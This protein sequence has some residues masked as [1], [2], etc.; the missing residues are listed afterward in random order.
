MANEHRTVKDILMITTG[1][2]LYGF[3]LVY[4]NIANDLAEG[5][6][7]GIALL[8]RFWLSIDPAISSLLL[9]IPM[10]LIG[11]KF[12]G[13]RALIYTLYGTVM[14]S[15]FLWIWQRVPLSIQLDNDLFI[16]GI[17]AGLGG[18]IGS[19]LIY[20]VGGTTGGSDI[21]A[22]ILEKKIG[23][24]MGKTLLIFDIFVLMLSLSYI[25][26]PHMMYTL[27][28]SYVFS[29]V[30]DFIQE[31]AYSARGM[32]VISNE[33]DAIAENLMLELER[34]VTFLKAEGAYSKTDKNVL[35]CVMGPHEIVTAKTIVHNTDPTAFLSILTVHEAMGEGFTYG[36]KPTRKSLFHQPKQSGKD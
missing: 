19:G 5:G 7:T 34:G 6:I 9:N 1:C 25:D 30:V 29:H 22:R 36:P 28:A 27:L 16:A 15:V 2:M 13:N 12:L 33:S 32:L 18:G 11:W 14:L 21:V 26:L 23:I 17:L 3:S 31:G 24:S 8:L 35:Y 10:I 4:V 20:R